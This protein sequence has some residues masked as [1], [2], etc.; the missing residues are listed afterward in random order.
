[1]FGI[2]DPMIWAAYAGCVVTVI[3]C[4]VYGWLKKDKDEDGDE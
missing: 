1:M 4:C 2:T 3:F